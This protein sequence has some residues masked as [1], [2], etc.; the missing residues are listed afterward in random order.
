[1]KHLT[2][3]LIFI[4]SS[5]TN[6][7]TAQS[8]GEQYNNFVNEAELSITNGNYK[9][10]LV[11]YNQA[12]TATGV[13]FGIDLYN[14]AV[15]AHKKNNKEQFLLFADRLADKGVDVSL[16]ERKIFEDYSDSRA[17]LKIKQ[18]A[19]KVKQKSLKKNS[20]YLSDLNEFRKKD[21]VYNKLRLTKYRGSW[22]LPDTLEVLFRNNTINLLNYIKKNGYYSEKKLRATI[23]LVGDVNLP[24]VVFLHYLE[25]GKDR[26]LQNEIKEMYIG[27]MKSGEI[28][29]GLLTHYIELGDR[30]F[31][32]I[33]NYA[34]KIF[35]CEIYRLREIPELDKVNRNREMCLQGSLND[36]EKKLVFAYCCN[37]DFEFHYSLIG[38][39]VSKEDYFYKASDVVGNVKDCSVE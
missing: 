17:F 37:T 11:K 25:M 1:M 30:V 36:Y 15:C 16:F 5:F 18:K 19:K 10:A 13:E 21:S 7:L 22:E 34:F 4:L 26:S 35:E 14:A 27:G 29:P 24:S 2:L 33:G 39:P 20:Q 38:S 12:F 31:N 23:T 28:K 9:Q 6:A 3:F 32:N 8:I